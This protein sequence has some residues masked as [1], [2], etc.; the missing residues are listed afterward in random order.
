MPITGRRAAPQPTTVV[1]AIIGL[2]LLAQSLPAL[3]EVNLTARGSAGAGVTDNV[4]SGS[5]GTANTKLGAIALVNGSLTGAWTG[6]NQTH[7][8]RYTFGLTRSFSSVGRQTQTQSLLWN[9]NY[10]PGGSISWAGSA[11]ATLTRMDAL[12]VIVLDTPIAGGLTDSTATPIPIDSQAA[13]PFPSA[14]MG[15]FS[16]AA[17]AT[18]TWRPTPILAWDSTTSAHMIVPTEGGQARTSYGFDEAI[19]H[20]RTIGL[21]SF[22]ANA[23]VGLL[24]AKEL[25]DSL[26]NVLY[27]ENET[28]HGRV[29][30]GWRRSLSPFLDVNVGVG[31]L[32]S[33]DPAGGPIVIGPSWRAGMIYVRDFGTVSG[34]YDHAPVPSLYLGRVSVSDRAAVNLSL[35]L[36]RAGRFQAVGLGTYNHARFLDSANQL[37]SATDILI[38]S[39]GLNFHPLL[40]PWSFALHYTRTQQSSSATVGGQALPNIERQTLLFI[41]TG[42]WSRYPP[43]GAAGGA[44]S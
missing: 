23:Q 35:P 4:S 9:G 31:G 37:G 42:T 17:H 39:A 8:L 44:G 29:L 33:M 38:A 26:G 25:T 40:W 13:A 27:P 24:V 6:Q 43:G 16:T 32:A 10:T 19:G 22:L 30:I 15:F 34:E 20:D 14:T 41:V 2:G 5:T 7:D 28:L 11:M 21:N 1:K 12:N 36:D 18:A 3:A